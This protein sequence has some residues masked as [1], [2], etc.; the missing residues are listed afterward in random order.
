MARKS[1]LHSFPFTDMY[2]AVEHVYAM[3]GP[4]AASMQVSSPRKLLPCS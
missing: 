1:L 2:S 4:T 3:S